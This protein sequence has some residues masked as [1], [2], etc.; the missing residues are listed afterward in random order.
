MKLWLAR[1]IDTEGGGGAVAVPVEGGLVVA[2]DGGFGLVEEAGEEGLGD[3]DV[4]G[5][6]C[7]QYGGGTD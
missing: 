5:S 1:L 3:G 7:C 4:V 2:G 6:W